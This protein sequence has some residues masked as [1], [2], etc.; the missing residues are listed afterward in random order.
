[1]KITMML[2]Q[3]F[4]MYILY[5]IDK[6][7]RNKY[8]D[9][10]MCVM[11]KLGDMGAIW[12]ALAFIL[13]LDKP[14]RY[15]GKMIVIT[16]MVSTALG[17]GLLKHLIRRIRPYSIKKNIGLLITRPISSYSFPSGHTLSSFAVAGVLSTYFIEYKL[18]FIVLASLIA[19][20][21]IYLY[22]H[23]PTDVIGGII[24]GLM[25]SKFILIFC[26]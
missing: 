10:F 7:L 2:I 23:Y 3:K 6:Y 20:S 13:L 21:R 9:I 16:L 18:L 8:L 15:I 5:A 11:T 12:I 1:M 14:Y 22:V 25:C 24:I 17:E 26:N 19:L 4:D